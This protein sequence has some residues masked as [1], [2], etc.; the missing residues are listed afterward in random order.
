[1][2]ELSATLGQTGLTVTAR[3][4]LGNVLQPQIISCPEVSGAGGLYIGNMPSIVAGYYDVIFYAN[5]IT[6]ACGP[7]DWDGTKEVR[8]ATLSTD[9][10]S[11]QIDTTEVLTRL[12]D[13]AP[14]SNGG[15]PTVNA[16]NYIAGIA[17][18]IN[19]LDELSTAISLGISALHDLSS[20]EVSDIVDMALASLNDLDSVEVSDIIEAALTAYSTAKIGSPVKI[21]YDNFDPE[22]GATF[23]DIT[24]SISIDTNAIAD[25]VLTRDWT[26]ITG[27]VPSKS[28]LQAL[29]FLRN[30]WSVFND[31]LKVYKE[32]NVTE[33]WTANV[34]SSIASDP[35]TGIT[36]S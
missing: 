35:I 31:E 18:T 8:L 29:R 10:D 23:E 3:L 9:M 26:L 11:I 19:T 2:N 14:G 27:T 1:M 34:D 28:T 4:Y 33:A 13:S 7:I 5:G 15:L 20:S 36:P 30:K 6:R 22:N 17:G 12:P 16:D 21:A 24:S 32:D 25:A